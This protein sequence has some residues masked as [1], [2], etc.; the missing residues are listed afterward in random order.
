VPRARLTGRDY[1]L[2]YLL[3]EQQSLTSRA[4]CSIGA[5]LASE[6]IGTFVLVTAAAAIFSKK[7][8]GRRRLILT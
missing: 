1:P 2:Q 5:N 8:A 3:D 7:V 4:I 6:I